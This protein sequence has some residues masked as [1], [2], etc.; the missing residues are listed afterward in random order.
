MNENINNH[1]IS[2]KCCV[3]RPL[4]AAKNPKIAVS[5]M[6]T[7]MMAKWREFSTNNPLK[8]LHVRLITN[9]ICHSHIAVV[10]CVL[11]VESRL[12]HSLLCPT[13]GLCYCQC[14]P[15]S[16]QC[17]CSCG[18]H[19][20]GRGRR[21]GRDWCCRRTCTCS[22][23]CHCSDTCCTPGSPGTSTPQGQDQRGQR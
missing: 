7:L 12:S 17:G 22:C 19:G 14:S 2:S 15:G 9:E 13:L 16:C 20:G 11:T 18:E 3:L 8:V 4:I 10:L 21:R 6:M 5:K 1:Y 23:P